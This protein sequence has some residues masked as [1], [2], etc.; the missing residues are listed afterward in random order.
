[1][2]EY[3]K[4]EWL[5]LYKEKIVRAYTN[6]FTH[7]GTITT[8]RAEGWRAK[9]KRYLQASRN[10]LFCFFR[11]MRNL[12]DAEHTEYE[13]TKG[14]GIISRAFNTGGAVYD[15]VAYKIHIYALGQFQNLQHLSRHLRSAKVY[16]P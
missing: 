15:A 12:W 14:Q 6:K 5:E 8:S 7:F 3:C 10:D 2:A 11:L 13:N 16:I 4:Y 9:L 1:M